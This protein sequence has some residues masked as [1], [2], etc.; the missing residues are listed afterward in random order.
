VDGVE[1]FY[2]IE[3]I[4]E[5]CGKRETS[6]IATGDWKSVFGNKSYQNIVVP[7]VLVRRSQTGK[8]L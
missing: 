5:E 6:P 4:L 3:E 2:I 7:H 8:S 1:I